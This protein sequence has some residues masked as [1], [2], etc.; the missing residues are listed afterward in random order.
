MTES[1][2]TNITWHEGNV[3][4]ADREKLLGFL[5]DS[6]DPNA[7]IIAYWMALAIAV[8]V[9]GAAVAGIY[10][11]P[12]PAARNPWYDEAGGLNAST[13]HAIRSGTRAII[14]PWECK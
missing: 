4:R 12:W 3:S 1:K 2:S 14:W 6:H 7:Q 8:I 13:P 9:I 5:I 10:I 11:A